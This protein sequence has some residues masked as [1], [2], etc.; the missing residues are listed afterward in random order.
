MKIFQLL[1]LSSLIIAVLAG[2][3][4]AKETNEASTDVFVKAIKNNQGVIV[5]AVGHQ[6]ISQNGMK[7]VSVKSMD[8]ITTQ[9]IQSDGLNNLFLYEPVEAD[10]VTTLPV[11]GNYTYSVTFKDEE[12]I[13][14]SNTLSTSVLAPPN[15]T[16]LVKSANGDSVYI[17]WDA[18]SG[19]HAYQLNVKKGTMPVYFGS[20]LTGQV[21]KIG[22]PTSAYTSY[23]NGIG[24]YTFA[25]SGLLY[26][27]T[28]LNYLQA[29]STSTKDIT[30]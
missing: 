1:V 2:C 14:Y 13:S 4:K 11:A 21:L 9:L 3:E 30:L 12:K 10:Y 22:I 19:A 25:L 5:Y 15:I 24:N 29:I 23:G 7:S 8:A 28:A 16:S 17:S 27:T 20:P 6:V 26:E 18:I